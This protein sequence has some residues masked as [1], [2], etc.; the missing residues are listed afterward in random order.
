M[1]PLAV[2]QWNHEHR[3]YWEDDDTL[4]AHPEIK[5]RILRRGQKQALKQDCKA[6][7]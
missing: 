6:R 3:V 5:R 7:K 1:Q 4:H 2:P